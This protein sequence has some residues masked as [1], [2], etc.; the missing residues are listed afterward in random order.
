MGS[1]EDI[2]F[3]KKGGRPKELSKK[4]A[5]ESKLEAKKRWRDKNKERI[6]IYNEM[7]R[8]EASK[9]SKK[10]KKHS[11][12]GNKRESRKHSK[13][14]H[15]KKHHSKKRRHSFQYGGHTITVLKVNEDG[16]KILLFE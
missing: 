2:I 15:S 1:S 6:S 3:Y 7:Y 10:S 8:E 13:K 12:R 14:H 9:K 11:R 5:H 4:E 16:S